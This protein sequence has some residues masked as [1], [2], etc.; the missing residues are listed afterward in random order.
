MAGPGLGSGSM[1]LQVVDECV[2]YY[3]YFSEA[4]KMPE[5]HR[6]LQIRLQLEQQ[7]FLVFAEEAG[8]LSTEIGSET[9]SINSALLQETLSEIKMLFEMFQQA[10]G[11]Y[12]DI[13]F[14]DEPEK[15][16][17]PQPSMMDLLCATQDPIAKIDI[18]VVPTAKTSL[19]SNSIFS[20]IILKARKL[21][22]IIV[23]P[24]R[25]VWVAFDQEAFTSLI[26]NLEVLNSALISLL[27]SSRSRRINQAIQISYQEIIQMKTDLQGLEAMVQAITYSTN[28]EQGDV[29]QS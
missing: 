6:Y 4:S 17:S 21:R 23:E 7:R 26:A 15:K 9:L 2:K 22:T 3:K 8:L 18:S 12:I 13:L 1:V 14:S 24:K 5:K 10:N 20:K 25:L 19:R 27:Q 11:K 28:Q 16:L 29:S